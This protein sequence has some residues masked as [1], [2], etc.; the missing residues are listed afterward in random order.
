MKFKKKIWLGAFASSLGGLLFGFD[1]AVIS[2]AEQGIMEYFKLSPFEHGFTNSVALIGT[3]I[4]ALFAYFPALYYGRKNSLILIGI[5]YFVSALGTA[6]IDQWHLFILFRFMGGI[7]VGASSVI[8]PMYI[9]EIAPTK[10]RGRLVGL[11]QLNIVLGILLA[12]LSNYVILLNVEQY[13][14]RWMLGVEAVP[15]FVFM[16]IC[17]WIPK[18]PRWLVSK[19]RI[20]EG[21]LVLNEISNDNPN[22]ALSKIKESLGQSNSEDRL[23]QWKYKTPIFLVVAMATFNQFAGINAIMYYAPRIFEMSGIGKETAFIQSVIIGFVNLLFT[24]LAMSVIDRFGRKILMLVGSIGM[25]ITLFSIAF[26]FYIGHQS[27]FGILIPLLVFIASFAFSQGAVIWVIIS[28]IFP[29][30]VRTAGISLGTFVHWFWAAVITGFFPWVAIQ[31]KGG[32][33]SFTFFGFAMVL[34]LLFVIKYLP[35]TK[36]VELENIKYKS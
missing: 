7:G 30:K 23:F 3:I 24:M 34:Q 16:I 8:A 14:W 4:G 1:T 13:S 22:E 18:S 10:L 31:P 25:I 35:E 2:G 32:V 21:L 6:I 27:T 15:A 5:L 36:G 17:F 20:D 29:N 11:F 28:E 26:L 19:G 12:Y 33:L 9:S